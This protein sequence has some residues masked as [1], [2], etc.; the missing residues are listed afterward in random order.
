[1]VFIKNWGGWELEG[2][3]G[4]ELD[5]P[6][7]HNKTEHA[8]CAFPVGVTVGLPFFKK[9]WWSLKKFVL[10]CPICQNLTKELTKQEAMARG[11]KL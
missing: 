1:M 6:K 5:C 9:P 8:V 3:K 7:C 2:F 11:P 10:V 4:V